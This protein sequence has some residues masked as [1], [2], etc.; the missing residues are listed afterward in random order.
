MRPVRSIVE[1]SP[2]GKVDCVSDFE[3][4]EAMQKQSKR[5]NVTSKVHCKHSN[6]D[7]NSD[8]LAWQGRKS[9]LKVLKHGD[10]GTVGSTKL[11]CENPEDSNGN[12]SKLGQVRAETSCQ[13]NV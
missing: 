13:R 2:L 12:K 7:L 10:R 11:R 9:L 8:L 6:S 5:V 4:K 3:G 1:P